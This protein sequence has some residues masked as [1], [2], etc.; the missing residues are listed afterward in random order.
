MNRL[1][2]ILAMLFALT[3]TGQ[4]TI[5][6]AQNDPVAAAVH[7]AVGRLQARL[8]IRVDEHTTLMSVVAVGK[9]AKYA[10]KLDVRKTR[11]PSKWYSLQKDV[12]TQKACEQPVVRKLMKDGATYQYLFTDIQNRYV[13]EFRVRDS[14]CP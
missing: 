5:A 6:H 12:L 2:K 11:V 7:A 9:T 14:N 3:L 10:F 8:P 13:N 1:Q 4:T